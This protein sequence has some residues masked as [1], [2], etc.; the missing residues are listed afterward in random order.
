M[1]M[2]ADGFQP[3]QKLLE[4]VMQ[5]YSQHKEKVKEEKRRV[6]REKAELAAVAASEAV[7]VGAVEQA[8]DTSNQD[9]EAFHSG[10]HGSLRQDEPGSVPESSWQGL[11]GIPP[12]DVGVNRSSAVA[13]PAMSP[14]EYA[15]FPGQTN[16]QFTPDDP[17]LQCGNGDGS[18]YEEVHYR[19]PDD[20][21]SSSGIHL[22][23]GDQLK[24]GFAPSLT[25]PMDLRES[26][27]PSGN[28]FMP[29]TNP[30]SGSNGFMPTESGQGVQDDCQQ[31]LSGLQD[32]GGTSG[33][34][35]TFGGFL[36][37]TDDAE[38][39]FVPSMN[40]GWQQTTWGQQTWED[41]AQYQPEEPLSRLGHH[42][43]C[44]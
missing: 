29:R 28:S 22:R 2:E 21:P 3:P 36:P 19:Q 5:L 35:P 44:R 9:R 16:V 6:R 40:S 32:N 34:V 38:R 12:A 15:L 42:R 27:N 37:R 17:A 11:D 1:Q 8:V 25:Y 41:L 4:N 13:P 43:R 30:D 24:E 23:W 18:P 20:E 33:F 10:S 39:G 31:Q 26:P 14:S 7:A